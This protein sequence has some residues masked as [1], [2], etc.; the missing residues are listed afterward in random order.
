M[1]LLS[2]LYRRLQDAAGDCDIRLRWITQGGRQHSA[3]AAPDPLSGHFRWSEHRATEVIS[4]QE[5]RRRLRGL[6]REPEAEV[7]VR[8]GDEELVLRRDARGTRLH[9]RRAA[10]VLT[11]RSAG[12]EGPRQYYLDL[13]RARPLLRC[14]GFMTE[15]GKVRRDMR[16][17][18]R[19]VDHFVELV[20]GLLR[21]IRPGPGGRITVVDCGCGKS[22]LSFVLNHY[23]REQ[24]GI[25]CRFVGIDVRPELMEECRQLARQ[26]G[27]ANMTFH[28]QPIRAFEPDEPIH[29]VV[30]LHAC[31]TATDEALGL[32]VRAEAAG[33]LLVPCCQA[34]VRAQMQDAKGTPWEGLVR[35]GVLKSR[36]ADVVTDAL[37]VLL[38]EAHGYRVS[39]VEYVSPLETPKNVMI[40]ARK[41]RERDVRAEALYRRLRDSLGLDPAAERFCRPIPPGSG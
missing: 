5:L 2:A 12:L 3:G 8:L 38:L 16:R 40:L 41:V 11:S 21:D 9:R 20:D 30:S 37:R 27:Y 25:P 24:M 31:D 34:E 14:L 6:L 7:V 23:L 19:Q 26:L 18:L 33:C 36:L 1:Q 13:G 32:A 35:H 15:E 39:V 10:E 28:Q 29:L 17:K 4:A 22:Y